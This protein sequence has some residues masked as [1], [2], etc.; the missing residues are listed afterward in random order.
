[1]LAAMANAVG[2]QV[3]NQIKADPQFKIDE[4]ALIAR[5]KKELP[6]VTIDLIRPGEGIERRVQP[7]SNGDATFQIDFTQSKFRK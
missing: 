3:Y 6:S 7:L 1:M 5:M 4:D 2:V